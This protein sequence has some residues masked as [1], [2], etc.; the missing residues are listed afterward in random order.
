M[1]VNTSNHVK[2][3]ISFQSDISGT[4]S[5]Q[6][7]TFPFNYTPHPLAKNA[8]LELQDYLITQS[9]WIHDFGIK[10]VSKSSLG[11][12]FGVLVVR[13]TDGKIGYL[14]AFSGILANKTILPHFVP[15]V[16]DRKKT[17][18][19]Y[20]AQE[21]VINK[22][23]RE[24]ETL[25]NSD[26]Y[27]NLKKQYQLLETQCNQTLSLK[28]Q[29]LKEEKKK[30]KQ[31]RV[32]ASLSLSVEDYVTYEQSL[33]KQS[34]DLEYGF[35]RLS[36]SL[37]KEVS[38]QLELL[39][40]METEIAQLKTLRK[41]KSG[42][43]QNA[44]FQEYQLLNNNGIQKGVIDIFTPLEKLP[45][46]GTGDCAAP[47][48]LQF[49]YQNKLTPLAMAEFWWGKSPPLEVRKHAH[50]YPSCSNKCKPILEHMLQG[51]PLD[52]DP[53]EKIKSSELQI[54]V[55]FEDEY[56]LVIN[57][58]SG[59]L[60]VPG[61]KIKESVESRMKSQ[62][63]DA[64]GPMLAHRL[65]MATSGLM[66]ISKSLSI[67]KHLQ[68]QFTERT[69]KKRYLAILEGNISQKSGVIRLPLRVDLDHRPAQV[70]DFEHGKLAITRW[71]VIEQSTN[72]TR[73]HFYPATGRTHQLR[74]HAS[75]P[76]G[77]NAPI[78]G[79]DIYGT[80][81]NRLFLQANYIK[82][83]HPVTHQQKSYTLPP[84]F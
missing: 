24:L 62:F 36:K 8:S 37:K 3:F 40:E 29:F 2:E 65:D 4:E 46:A 9:D 20:E 61:K 31:L 19:F 78:K 48:L 79:D 32:E 51:L 64:T 42:N 25:L 39:N 57:K 10:S 49:A 7:F 22:L 69:V 84:D 16:Y 11:K 17:T 35:K 6:N 63:P 21:E 82:F 28:K 50:F 75:H 58:P 60:S 73:I 66:L 15:P 44:L 5:P 67:H 34:M 53:L 77:L 45:P 13:D 55:L 27:L 81:S 33:R 68:A 72:Q 23:N 43:I 47:K 18:S 70:V 26:E 74:V 14:A 1:S 71:E 56:L 54:E 59:L 12:M 80:A 30:R 38:I 41:Q 52:Q 83:V 76:K